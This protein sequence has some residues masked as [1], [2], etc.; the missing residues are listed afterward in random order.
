MPD[1]VDPESLGRGDLPF[2]VVA[3]HPG[4]ALRGRENAPL[5][6]KAIYPATETLFL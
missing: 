1:R 4:I 3:D 2:E 5:R 6:R